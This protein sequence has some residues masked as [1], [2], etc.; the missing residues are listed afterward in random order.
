MKEPENPTKAFMETLDG[1]F[2]GMS[3]NDYYEKF[4]A[5][6]KGLSKLNVP[7]QNADIERCS[8]HALLQALIIFSEAAKEH[9]PNMELTPKQRD[10]YRYFLIEAQKHLEKKL[11]K[12]LT[13]KENNAVLQK[14]LLT[15]DN[16]LALAIAKKSEPERLEA[17][18]T[19][20]A[21]VPLSLYELPLHEFG[22]SEGNELHKQLKI[23]LTE[24][25][26][27]DRHWFT[28][29]VHELQ[30]NLK[31]DA[32][33]YCKN[34]RIILIQTQLADISLMS[35]EILDKLSDLMPLTNEVK[36]LLDKYEQHLIKIQINTDLIP[37]MKGD[38]EVIRKNLEEQTIRPKPV[39]IIQNID[40]QDFTNLLSGFYPIDA[41]QQ[42]ITES[43][44]S[45]H[46]LCLTGTPG[47]GK[48]LLARKIAYDSFLN[49]E[50]EY[51]IIWWIDADDGSVDNELVKLA[52]HEKIFGEEKVDQWL[53]KD[54][55]KL[56]GVINNL[57]EKLQN[58]SWLIVFDNAMDSVSSTESK[59]N[60]EKVL[61][62][63]QSEYLPK[64]KS[65]GHILLTSRNEDWGTI[66]NP[67][68]TKEIKTWD[69]KN[70][71][72]YLSTVE[73]SSYESIRVKDINQLEIFEGLPLAISI[74]KKYI[75]DS[76]DE[77]KY[78]FATFYRKWKA[79]EDYFL[80]FESKYYKDDLKHKSLRVT[81]GLSYSA[82]GVN[83]K[84]VIDLLS[85][86][87]PDDLPVKL[88][89]NERFKDELNIDWE[90]VRLYLIQFRK[91]SL[92]RFNETTKLYSM[93]RVVQGCVR[94]LQESALTDN[95]K[96]AL[97]LA[98]DAFKTINDEK[99]AL[100]KEKIATKERKE[101]NNRNWDFLIPHI[102][103]LAALL[104]D[105]NKKL[106]E[107][108]NENDQERIEA[109][110]FFINV[111]QS[112]SD[113]GDVRSATE[114]FETAMQMAETPAIEI[115]NQ[116]KLD[117]SKAIAQ[118]GLAKVLFLKGQG[119]AGLDRAEEL[120]IQAA[121]HFQKR[122]S[123]QAA[124]HVERQPDQVD[125]QVEYIDCMN[126]VVGKI[127]QRKCLF[128]VCEKTYKDLKEEVDKYIAKNTTEDDI[129][130]HIVQKYKENET[131]KIAEKRGSVYHNLGSLYWTW[132]RKE[133]KDYQTARGY[134]KSAI[135]FQDSM[136]TALENA[137]K[138]Y[139]D[140]KILDRLN[141]ANNKK[142]F[143]NVSRMIYGAVLSLL[144]EFKGEEGEWEQH[145]EALE[146]FKKEAFEK[147]RYAYTAYYMLANSWDR[148][149][150][151]EGLPDDFNETELLTDVRKHDK[152]LAG[153]DE[154]YDLIKKII[155]LREDVRI[156]T[157]KELTEQTPDYK[158]LKEYY[159]EL[160]S[161]LEA[162]K[163]TYGRDKNSTVRY[164]DVDTCSVSAILDYAKFLRKKGK[165]RDSKKVAEFGLIVTKDIE[166][167]R[168][169]E[170]EALVKGD[171]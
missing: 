74:A 80:N 26:E 68:P 24:G 62:K 43:L 83:E 164:Y 23:W 124:S 99:K 48:S 146:F 134:F 149:E 73:N 159:E 11:Q 98:V 106:I 28:Y 69:E 3:G 170:L 22:Y 76:D 39:K 115:T 38:I 130:D 47:V 165:S 136:V 90:T 13:L 77:D 95:Y 97:F 168:I 29:Y 103:A 167:P 49:P 37:G 96:L 67:I 109:I 46:K 122:S 113:I 166:Y 1:L 63:Y 44:K 82:I 139:T 101:E 56:E 94:L 143:L 135:D 114:Q 50:N 156:E 70:V 112:Q 163:Y 140:E 72:K 30:A 20:L 15:Q 107:A 57:Y 138:Q 111:G 123:Q 147:R 84:R 144:K 61:E 148:K 102:D 85:C 131:D 78:D 71:T 66:T 162:M 137:K 116:E 10:E 41:V 36:I 92:G 157:K 59:D 8:R 89:C 64:V 119:A 161:Q 6:K 154:K 121:S 100:N 75:L 14:S 55:I 145:N 81:V 151:G 125:Y 155:N 35:T 40:N 7:E 58:Y 110:Q 133:E 9:L 169:N 19:S 152:T 33:L 158:K 51:E 4:S 42:E 53:N 31:K 25:L 79:N 27:N 18:K 34:A 54:K 86:F 120:A 91:C 108:M 5:Y 117:D 93:H 142:L 45:Q 105:G 2:G 171:Q 12:L 104:R 65:N 126:D 17:L 153:N 127:Q 52:K 141:K 21:P 160:Q 129:Y 60:I 16:R 132:G 87:G 150:L 118:R 88:I 128:E 32:P